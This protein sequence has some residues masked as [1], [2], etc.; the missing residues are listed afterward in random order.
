MSPNEAALET[1]HGIGRRLCRTLAAALC[2]AAL[3]VVV[4]WNISNSIS[5]TSLNSFDRGVRTISHLAG[6]RQAWGVFGRPPRQDTWFVYQARL[7]NGAKV[8]LLSGG[9]ETLDDK[10]SLASRQFSNHRWRKLHYR[11]RDQSC[12][13]YRA[14]LA[15]Y[16]IREWDAQHGADEQVVRLDVYYFTQSF[17]LA[18]TPGDHARTTLAQVIVGDEGGN[19]AEALR[20]DEAF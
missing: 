5:T 4:Y 10:P 16:V 20:E 9:A 17:D 18:G 11:R 1:S 15:N 3:A 13:P 6:L 12:V 19:F 14:A 8:D 7:K 2:F